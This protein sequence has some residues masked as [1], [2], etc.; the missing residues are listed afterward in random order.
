MSRR[1]A[2]SPRSA[3]SVPSAPVASPAP[4]PASSPA[5]APAPV[6]A[7]TPSQT[8]GPFYGY[9]LPF[10]GGGEIAPAGAPGTITVHGRV[11]DGAGGPVPDA[12]LEFWQTDP[13]GTVPAVPGSIRRD[14][15]VGV[16]GP[17]SVLGRNAFG[18]TGFGRI[19]VDA[20]GHWTLHT[21]PPGHGADG[22]G[23]R[24]AG[25]GGEDGDGRRTGASA[26]FISVC[27]FARGLLHHL[28]TRL[29]LPGHAE[30][31]PADPLLS[32]LAPER[33]RTL[34]AV[35]ER[36]GVFRFDIRLQGRN[37]DGGGG[38]GEETVFLDFR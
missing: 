18:F 29:Y 35:E 36:E 1:P 19:P 31:H 37:R 24:V 20:D 11:Y 17:G 28:F 8:I 9:A 16:A 4:T 7:P 21:L 26:P 14:P 15:V 38:G 25:D 10:T 33:R 6:L 2:A 3:P 32:S 27:V 13:E 30:A 12:L 5:P 34:V 23:E 22:D